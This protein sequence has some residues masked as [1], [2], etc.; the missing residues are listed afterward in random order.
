VVQLERRMNQVQVEEDVWG[1]AVVRPAR[2]NRGQPTTF[3]PVIGTSSNEA[4]DELRP[5]PL[6]YPAPGRGPRSGPP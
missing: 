6:P 5:G 1:L 3:S 2:S 4:R